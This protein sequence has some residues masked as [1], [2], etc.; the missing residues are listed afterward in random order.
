MRI[1]IVSLFA[2]AN[3]FSSSAQNTRFLASTLLDRGHEIRVVCGSEHEGDVWQDGYLLTRIPVNSPDHKKAWLGKWNSDAYIKEQAEP[4]FQEWHPDLIYVGA[5]N[6]LIDFPLLGSKL[7]IPIVQMVHDYSILCLQIWLQDSWGQLCS[8]PK[9]IEKCSACIQN[10]LG[11]KDQIKNQIL[12]LPIFGNI[13]RNILRKAHP[14]NIH[15]DS[16]VTKSLS[17][18]ENYRQKVNFFIAQS[19]MVKQ[20]LSEYGVSK[21]NI[22]LLPQFIGE[23]K[24]T[25]Y[26]RSAGIPGEDR[27]LYILFIGR[28]TKLK[29]SKLLLDA[30][31]E[32]QLALPTELWVITRSVK[33]NPLSNIDLEKLADNK[34][35]K[36]FTNLSGADVSRKIAKADLCVVPSTMMELAS[37]V[38]LEAMAQKVPVIASSSVGNNYLINNGKNGRVFQTGD[39]DALKLC[40]EEIS[41]NPAQLHEWSRNLLVPIS[42]E[43]WAEK[44]NTIFNEAL[45]NAERFV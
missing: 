9:S 20:K 26:S 42:K 32:S 27:P 39:K 37:R 17:F 12:S 24:L 31:S 25:Q 23:E 40:L 41:G 34:A 18:M 1:L 11:W 10:S 33:Q 45:T 14:Y 16:A 4:Y 3:N 13:L 44:I 38:V 6:G 28:W 2:E 30:Y 8:G 43:N 7:G 15:V 5:W 22:R 29:G 19:P 21:E 35:I 36:F